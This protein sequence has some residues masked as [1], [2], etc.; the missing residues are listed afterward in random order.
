MGAG[1]R[2]YWDDLA[3]LLEAPAG[4]LTAQATQVFNDNVATAWTFGTGSE[5][6]DEGDLHDPSGA[7]TRITPK[8]AGTYFF[9]GTS[10][11]GARNDY[12]DIN[13][14]WRKNG[15]SSRAPWTR[16]S[17]PLIS[18]IH[19]QVA[20]AFEKMNGTTDYMEFMGQYNNTG[21]ANQASNQSGQY[22]AGV[23]WFM[24]GGERS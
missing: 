16:A 5:D 13:T 7:P 24:V 22:T 21:S 2:A 18:G 10:M 20:W 9:I 6:F 14:G 12:A 19:S 3:V 17:P 8:I 11:P 15:S 23:C 4:K 1:D